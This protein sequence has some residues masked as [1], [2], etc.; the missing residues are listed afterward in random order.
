MLELTN[1]VKLFCPGRIPNRPYA[2]DDFE[3]GNRVNGQKHAIGKRYIQ[4]NPP[5]H[6]YRLIFDIDRPDSIW[7]WD[8]AFLARPSWTAMNPENGHAHIAYEL[9]V[10]VVTSVNGHIRPLQYLAAIEN[11]YCEE[12]DADRGYSGLM[13]KNPLHDFWRT[14]VWRK[15]PYELGELAEYVKE[16]NRPRKVCSEIEYG[17]GRN[18]E[19]FHRLRF[20]AYRHVDQYRCQGE[21][22][23]DHWCSEVLKK[24]LTYNGFAN[25]LQLMEVKQVAH[26]V[27]KWTWKKF[28]G[29]A[30]SDRKFSRRQAFLGRRG[31]RKSGEVRRQLT[32]DKREQACALIQSGISKAEAARILEVN[33]S[34]ITR[35]VHR[36]D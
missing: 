25:P 32:A 1:D 36:D 29:K 10:P 28:T 33:R 18:V 3:W 22:I 19:L 14:H 20:W 4:A 21:G 2:T 12:L 34:T 15:E 27:A 9:A 30:E 13:C 5:C 17:L 16:L 24:A 26:S 23:Y 11:A 7:A 35:W 8:D 6:H 31:G